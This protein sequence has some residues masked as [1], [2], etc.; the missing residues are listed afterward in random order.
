[1]VRK[2]KSRKIESDDED[3]E[4]VDFDAVEE[5]EPSSP[6]PRYS[7]RQRKKQIIID[8]YDYEDDDERNLIELHKSDNEYDAEE[9]ESIDEDDIEEEFS[10]KRKPRARGKRRGSS[11]SNS[12]RKQAAGKADSDSG[13]SESI[14]AVV[15]TIPGTTAPEIDSDGPIDF[16]DIIR[17][18]IVVN[19]KRIDFENYI[20]KNEIEVLEEEVEKK[21]ASKAETKGNKKSGRPKRRCNYSE[22]D[23]PSL[24][25]AQINEGTSNSDDIPL[26]LALLQKTVPDELIVPSP[27]LNN[28][29]ITSGHLNSTVNGAAAPPIVV[30]NSCTFPNGNRLPVISNLTTLNSDSN[31]TKNS[32]IDTYV[33]KRYVPIAPKPMTPLNP[34]PAPP[35]APPK[36]NGCLISV[37]NLNELLDKGRLNSIKPVDC[38]SDSDVEIIEEKREIIV[39]DD[40]DDDD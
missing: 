14:M 2:R 8:D 7:L 40:D 1:M 30:L 32:S 20:Q 21:V 31:S 4:D 6:K 25:E 23:C 36:P 37:K 13:Q 10:L 11:T 29:I 33:S 27:E 16:E 39:L 12:S 34:V 35:K 28:T 17:A 15:R 22:T 19:K 38:E 3:D 5:E 26:S 18:D 24:V 9:R